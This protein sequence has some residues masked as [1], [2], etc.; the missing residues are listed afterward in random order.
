M[1]RS[2]IF[3]SSQKASNSNNLFSSSTMPVLGIGGASGI[4]SNNSKD[5]ELMGDVIVSADLNGFLKIFLNPTRYKTGASNFF[6]NR[7]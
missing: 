2:L 7:I 3:G 4:I 6:D 5:R 1:D